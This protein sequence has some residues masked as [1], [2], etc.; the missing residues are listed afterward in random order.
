MTTIAKIIA[1]Q[2]KSQIATARR[3]RSVAFRAR[4]DATLAEIVTP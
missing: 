2:T 1:Q 3:P 4:G